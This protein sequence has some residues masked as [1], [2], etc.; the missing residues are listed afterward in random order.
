MSLVLI[1]DRIVDARVTVV[2]KNSLHSGIVVE[3]LQTMMSG[4]SES[5]C[6]TALLPLLEVEP[7]DQ[8][9]LCSKKSPSSMYQ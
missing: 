6:S 4:L 3:A 5:Q 9:L 8:A 7:L 1:P 2:Y